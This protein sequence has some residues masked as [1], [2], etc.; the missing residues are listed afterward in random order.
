M[1]ETM[2]SITHGSMHFVKITKIGANEKKY[3][4]SILMVQQDSMPSLINIKH[5]KICPTY[6]KIYNLLSQLVPYKPGGHPHW[7]NPSLFVKQ[8]PFPQSHPSHGD[9][10]IQQYHI[11]FKFKQNYSLHFCEYLLRI[12]FLIIFFIYFYL[13]LFLL[14]NS[15]ISLCRNLFCYPTFCFVALC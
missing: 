6:L 3:F 15:I 14:F 5:I 8:V 9:S 1:V 11:W 12:V 13:L 10:V 4:H 2:N 7:A